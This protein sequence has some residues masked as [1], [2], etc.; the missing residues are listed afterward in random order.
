MFRFKRSNLDDLHLLD[1][2]LYDQDSLYPAL[3]SDIRQASAI[4]IIESPFISHR[5][6]SYLLPAIKSVANRGVKI[7]INTRD[8]DEH[9]ESMREQAVEAIDELQ[10]LG[11]LV[12]YTTRLHRKLVIIDQT[13]L[14]EGS[15][16]VLSQSDSCEIMRRVVSPVM[17]QQLISFLSLKQWYNLAKL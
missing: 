6:V 5:R 7:V 14:W 9:E 12:L 15:L 10:E 17:C 8:P 2:R 16:N 11:A 1:S 4:I 13:T 3:L